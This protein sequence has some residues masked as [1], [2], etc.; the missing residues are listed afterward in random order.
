MASRHQCETEHRGSGFANQHSAP[1]SHLMA[2]PLR[3]EFP[4]AL[5]HL[6]ARGNAREAIYREFKGSCVTLNPVPLKLPDP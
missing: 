1:H 2:R 4:D 6:T 3:I 5:Y